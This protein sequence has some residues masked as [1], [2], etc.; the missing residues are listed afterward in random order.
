MPSRG[1]YSLYKS[2]ACSQILLL[3]YTSIHVYHLFNFHFH[4]FS[5]SVC[6]YRRF[7]GATAN[8]EE[9]SSWNLLWRYLV[10]G[11]TT[12]VYEVINFVSVS[13]W[14]P[15]L[16]AAAEAGKKQLVYLE[17]C[18]KCSNGNLRIIIRYRTLAVW[19]DT[20][21]RNNQRD[22]L[23]T[24]QDLVIVLLFIVYFLHKSLF[25]ESQ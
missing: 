1:F 10:P 24:K 5:L 25:F 8:R 3:P 13:N 11:K 19:L 23:F 22:R 15:F 2:Q 21:S 14:K 4:L 12:Y 20:V 6:R 16:V 9:R 17:L 7:R 18:F